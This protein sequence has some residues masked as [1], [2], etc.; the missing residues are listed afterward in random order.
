MEPGDLA[1][2]AA[3]AAA[4]GQS[5]GVEAPFEAL[6][7]RYEVFVV[8]ADTGAIAGFAAAAPLSGLAGG[9]EDDGSEG[10]FWIGALAVDPAWRGEGFGAALLE[11][12][13]ARAQWFF[14]R[15]LGLSTGPDEAALRW[16]TRHRFLAVDP[17][18]WTPALRKQIG[19]QCADGPSLQ[20]RRL[21]IR[22]L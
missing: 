5:L 15:A 17:A 12:V 19:A 11:A 21:L 14:C 9:G 3:I 7:P 22:W 2:L 4:S 10:C 1:S 8:E 6:L 18:N 13:T 20:A 16:A